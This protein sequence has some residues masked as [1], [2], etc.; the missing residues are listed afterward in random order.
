M[1][2]LEARQ[3]CGCHQVYFPHLVSDSIYLFMTFYLKSSLMRLYCIDV[4]KIIL[5]LSIIN[6]QYVKGTNKTRTAKLL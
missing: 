4:T 5:E 2:F 1:R 3:A 6:V